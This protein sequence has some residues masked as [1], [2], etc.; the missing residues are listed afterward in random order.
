[1]III[2]EFGESSGIGDFKFVLDNSSDE[3]GRGVSFFLNSE[4]VV[5]LKTL[6]LC[7]IF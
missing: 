1:M 5:Q 6:N 4:N 2:L 7:W 3:D